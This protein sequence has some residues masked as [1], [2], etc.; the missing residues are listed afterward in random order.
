MPHSFLAYIDESGDD[1]LT[2]LYRGR[3]GRRGGSSRWLIVSAFV[4]RAAHDSKAI[5]WRNEI[6]QK[7]EK[8]T[9]TLH[10]TD[11]THTQRLATA[12]YLSTK[13]FRAISVLS[14]KESI[15]PDTFA[16]SRQYYFY[17]TRYLVERISWICRDYVRA[18]QGD[19]RVKITFSRRGSMSYDIFRNYL[20]RLRDNQETSIYWPAI[21]IDGIDAKDHTTIA[22]LQLADGIASAMAAGVDPDHLGNCESRY[23]EILKPRIYNRNGNYFSYGVKIVPERHHL[24][25]SADQRR[26]VALFGE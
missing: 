16:N 5:T 14:N 24:R 9:K 26:F 6:L 2:G 12:Q 22:G 1:G 11:L 3:D 19:D 13:P 15:P 8:R 21:D 10:F 25:L 7:A 20:I 23:A 4:M 17:L 18:G